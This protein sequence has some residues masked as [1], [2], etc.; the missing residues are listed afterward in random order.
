MEQVNFHRAYDDFIFQGI[1]HS[2]RKVDVQEFQSIENRLQSFLVPDRSVFSIFVN[3]RVISKMMIPAVSGTRLKMSLA[4][5]YAHLAQ[6]AC[7]LTA[8]KIREG[9]L[10]DSLTELTHTE[11][12]PLP[13]D[14]IT[15]HPFHYHREGDEHFS[16]YSAGWNQVDDGGQLSLEAKRGGIQVRKGD[17]VWHA[18]EV[19]KVSK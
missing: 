9:Q 16:L 10:P 12:H 6:V 8:H 14:V 3:H 7:L 11:S 13:N 18:R 4:Q 15:G 19:T 5:N 1:D 2:T 17:W